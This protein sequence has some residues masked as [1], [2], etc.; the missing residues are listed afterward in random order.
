MML[1]L[2]VYVVLLTATLLPA[3]A[4]ANPDVT[5]TARLLAILLDSGRVVVGANQ[6]VINEKENGDKGFTPELFE[7]Q[8]IEM[9]ERRAG[10]DLNN[11][12]AAK[13]PDRAKPL[14][15]ELMDASKQTV[16]AAQPVINK[17]GLG[18]KN[19][20]PATFGTQTA[21]RFSAKTGVYLK[22]TTIDTLLRNPKNKA[23][24]FETLILK[25]FADPAY[26]RQ[27]ER[28]VSNVV[29]GGRTIR[30]ML[31]LYYGEK[32][33]ICHGEPRGEQDMSAY[34]K[35][36]GKLGDLGGAISVKLAVK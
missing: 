29:D 16:K 2:V 4:R 17:K 11:L 10:V 30:L 5:E 22:Q 15:V 6:A 18:F 21:G 36:G 14:L 35:E 25:Q 8:V 24:D 31:P 20:I 7:R 19:F 13:I 9:F 33:L 23:D 12:A 27:G 3:P 32:C 1:R 34:R 28:V 26:P